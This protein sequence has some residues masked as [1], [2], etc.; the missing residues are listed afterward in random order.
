LS[1]E[2]IYLLT[3]CND[4][5][6]NIDVPVLS[7]ARLGA[8]REAGEVV[9]STNAGAAPATVNSELLSPK[10]HW[11]VASGRPDSSADL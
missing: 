1:G 7:I 2:I 10:G 6:L 4:L 3:L 8:K 11:S 9:I 5:V